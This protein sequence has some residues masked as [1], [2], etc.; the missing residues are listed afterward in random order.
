MSA[1]VRPF[2]QALA[3]TA[4]LLPLRAT[5]QPTE[6]HDPLSRFEVRISDYA[7]MSNIALEFSIEGGHDDVVDVYVRSSRH[8]DLYDLAP[9]AVM[10][11]QDVDA[12]MRNLSEADKAGYRSY[13]DY[14]QLLDQ[15]QSKYPKLAQVQNEDYMVS[16]GGKRILVLKI[17]KN[18][19]K[20]HPKRPNVVIT[21]STH[22]DEWSST[23]IPMNVMESMLEKYGKDDRVTRIFDRV[24][25]Y[26]VPVMSPDSFHRSRH[27]HG[28]DPNRVYPY[29][30]RNRQPSIKS[31]RGFMKWYQTLKPDGV[32]DFHA[33]HGSILWPWGC[34]RKSIPAADRKV[35]SGLADKM[36]AKTGYRHGQITKVLYDAPGVSIDAW[37]HL[38]DTV[39]YTIEVGGSSKKPNPS[40]LAK[41]IRDNREHIY[42]FFEHF[43]KGEPEP[44]DEDEDESGSSSTGGEDTSETDDSTEGDSTEDEGGDK[45]SDTDDPSPKDSPDP[46]QN[47]KSEDEDN[48]DHSPETSPD[49]SDPSDKKDSEEKTNDSHAPSADKHT[50]GCQLNT[51]PAAPGWLYWGIALLSL[52]RYHR[53]PSDDRGGATNA[54]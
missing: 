9:S 41:L 13:N 21:G 49:P 29:P 24:N 7:T 27:V 16:K 18:V 37:Y 15:L 26:W 48:D 2:H 36:V 8:K 31:A 51:S 38:H 47:E 46:S 4:V 40:S 34:S 32:I 10:V 19:G 6:P 52:G 42:V 53:R 45:D 50:R 22:G 35:F 25:T 54:S 30:G 43:I 17:T 39:A 20:K 44:E 3:L 28:V 1:S 5:A 23:A 12:W 11:E 33:V 14:K